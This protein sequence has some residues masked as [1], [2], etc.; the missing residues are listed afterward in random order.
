MTILRVTRRKFVAALGSA[1]AWPVVARAQAPVMPVIGFLNGASADTYAHTVTVFRHGLAEMGF[2][3]GQNVLIEFRWA[4]YQYERLPTL[5]ADLINRKVAVLVACGGDR[6]AHAAKDATATI[7]IVFV[8]GEPLTSG[9][10]TSLN[11]PGGNLTGVNLFAVT[12]AS[13][14]MELL[15]ELVPNAK[16]IGVLRNPESPEGGAEVQEVEA[17]ARLFG[18]QIRLV[19]VAS[20]D[21]DFRDAFAAF[22]RLGAKALLILSDFSFSGLRTQFVVRSAVD[23]LPSMYFRREFVAAGGLV[24]YGPNF[25]EQYRQAGIYTGRIL[26]GVKPT[27][28]PVLQPDKF[29]LVIN[30]KTAKSLG[31]AVPPALLARAD[32]VIE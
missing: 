18:L 13:K 30:L 15:H 10:V 4:D 23:A 25:D 24:S 17:A 16:V 3:E 27:D 20:Q 19:D 6:A 9:L 2:V 26:R 12:L 8:S 31:L 14:Q 5:A 1:A 7:P 11:R 22:A 28:L 29:E 32:E 21:H